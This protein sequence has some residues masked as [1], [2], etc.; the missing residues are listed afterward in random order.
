MKTPPHYQADRRRWVVMRGAWAHYHP[1]IA[2]RILSV[3]KNAPHTESI[4]R[5]YCVVLDWASIVAIA[6]QCWHPVRK[7]HSHCGLFILLIFFPEG[8]P[9]SHTSLARVAQVLMN[10]IKCPLVVHV[11]IAVNAKCW[12]I[13]PAPHIHATHQNH[14]IYT[15]TPNS[16]IH[17]RHW[18]NLCSKPPLPLWRKLHEAT[19]LCY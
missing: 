10:K 9:V 17:K 19:S 14:F 15:P 6:A 3:F 5:P 7:L 18:I 12:A 8:V 13:F 11:H 1:P 2:M 4:P 16:L